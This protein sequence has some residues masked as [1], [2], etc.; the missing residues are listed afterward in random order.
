MNDKASRRDCLMKQYH[1]L[2]TG[3]QPF[4]DHAENP[5]QKIAEALQ[6][7]KH[8]ISHDV[9]FTVESRILTVDTAGASL[10]SAD[11]KAGN[12][13]G[14]NLI[15]HLGLDGRANKMYVETA[16]WNCCATRQ[17]TFFIS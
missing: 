5:S 7:Y 17:R 11:L 16:A 2:V 6:G 12:K 13:S 1:V 4:L 15:V 9:S 14:W 10:I 8:A 3:Y